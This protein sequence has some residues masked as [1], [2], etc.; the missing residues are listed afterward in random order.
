MKIDPSVFDIDFYEVFYKYRNIL[1]FQAFDALALKREQKDK[2][3]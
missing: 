3:E 2:I 1:T